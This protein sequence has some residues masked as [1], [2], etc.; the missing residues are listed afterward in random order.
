MI[1]S[2]GYE[3][4]NGGSEMACVRSN[5]SKPCCF[6]QCGISISTRFPDSLSPV[7]EQASTNKRLF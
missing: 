5:I 2:L 6:S 4:I 7:R 1:N 3:L